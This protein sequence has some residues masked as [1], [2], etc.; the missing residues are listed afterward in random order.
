MFL[1]PA[2]TFFFFFFPFHIYFFL[3]RGLVMFFCIE[4]P[5]LLKYLT[6][7][8]LNFILSNFQDLKPGVLVPCQ[9]SEFCADFCPLVL[10]IH[11]LCLL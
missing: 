4:K 11:N 5:A 3:F 6:F 10:F 9:R 7:T 1:L 8:I 2:L